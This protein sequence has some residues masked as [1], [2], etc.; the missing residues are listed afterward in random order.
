VKD[1]YFGDINDYRKFGLLR[2]LAESDVQLVVS[3]MLTPDDDGPDGSLTS[4]LSQPDSWIQFDPDLYHILRQSVIDQGER[5]I[6]VAS[7]ILSTRTR[8]VKNS[9]DSTPGSRAAWLASTLRESGPGKLVFLDPDNGLEVRSVTKGS[10]NGRKYLYWDEVDDL[11]SSGSSLLIYQHFPR[12]RRPPFI[13]ALQEKLLEHCTGS[14]VTPIET[15]NVVFLLVSQKDRREDLLRQTRRAC[16][17]WRGELSV[18]DRSAFADP[19]AER[20]RTRDEFITSSRSG[21]ELTVSVRQIEWDGPH[22]PRSSFHIER[23]PSSARDEVIEACIE[24][25]LSDRRFFGICEECGEMN[26]RGWMM[27]A[28]LCQSCAVDNHGVVF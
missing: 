6:V 16:Q 26:P 27:D 5:S 8:F 17:Q 15:S 3:W 10:K 1:Q 11:W 23:L 18:P 4:Y 14:R 24:R 22:D 28:D 20:R 21:N 19:L 25:V 13:Q 2:Y 7:R 12:V 9:L